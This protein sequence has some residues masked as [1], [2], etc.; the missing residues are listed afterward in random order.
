[1]HNYTT[2]TDVTLT[3][4]KENMVVIICQLWNF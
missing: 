3:G 4:T 2:D 1:M